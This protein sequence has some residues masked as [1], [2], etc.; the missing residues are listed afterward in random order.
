[1]S[2]KAMG[3]DFELHQDLP[4]SPKGP[5]PVYP[6]S[7]LCSQLLRPSGYSL[8]HSAVLM[9]VVPG[10]PGMALGICMGSLW[11]Y[12]HCPHCVEG[13]MGTEAKRPAHIVQLAVVK[14]RI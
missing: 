5:N 6:H 11:M 13:D 14:L 2:H 3:S 4:L 12:N 10:V 1:M 7:S 8:S 9:M